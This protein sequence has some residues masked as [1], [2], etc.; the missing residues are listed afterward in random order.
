[1]KGPIVSAGTEVGSERD[2][3]DGR[4]G[5]ERFGHHDRQRRPYDPPCRPIPTNT[6]QQELQTS[7]K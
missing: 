7:K 6:P 3:R 1:M 4:D 2:E 5:N